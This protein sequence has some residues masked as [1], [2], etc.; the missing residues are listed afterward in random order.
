MPFRNTGGLGCTGE[1]LPFVGA[2]KPFED[3]LQFIPQVYAIAGRNRK[4]GE[5]ATQ[6]RTHIV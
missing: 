4:H 1:I 3:I 2:V 5:E 6:K